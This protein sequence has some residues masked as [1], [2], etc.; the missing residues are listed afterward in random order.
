MFTQVTPCFWVQSF[1]RVLSWHWSVIKV[2]QLWLRFTPDNFMTGIGKARNIL[3][4]LSHIVVDFTV[5]AV[6][7][8][9]TKKNSWKFPQ[10][11]TRVHLA[12]LS[13]AGRCAICLFSYTFLMAFNSGQAL[14]V[15]VILQNLLFVIKPESPSASSVPKQLLW[16]A[17][18]TAYQ[19]QT[20]PCAYQHNWLSAHMQVHIYFTYIMVETVI[21]I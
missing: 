21:W 6:C 1:I 14:K 7:L 9:Q 13:S 20:P 11:S 5:I 15:Q 17:H 19:I 8:S 3:S 4:Q 12:G 10:T 2:L 16:Q 18:C